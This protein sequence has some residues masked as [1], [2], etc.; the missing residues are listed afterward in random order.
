MQLRITN[1]LH[2]SR[3]ESFSQADLN[4]YNIYREFIILPKFRTSEIIEKRAVDDYFGQS[5]LLKSVLK[6]DPIK[7]DI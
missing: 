6:H 2:F 1:H 5:T 4:D 7:Q 3:N